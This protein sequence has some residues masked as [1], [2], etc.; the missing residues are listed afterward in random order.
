[1]TSIEDAEEVRQLRRQASR[2]YRE[3]V[4]IAV[5]ATGVTMLARSLMG[6]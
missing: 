6:T 5:L 4:A 3:A 2:V 1:M